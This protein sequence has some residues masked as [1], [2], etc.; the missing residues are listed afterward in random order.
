MTN[1]P[2][3]SLPLSIELLPK[4]IDSHGWMCYNES[5]FQQLHSQIK[6]KEY[7]NYETLF[8]YR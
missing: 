4:N 7:A 2:V 8:L 6:M 3:L 1:L 5:Y